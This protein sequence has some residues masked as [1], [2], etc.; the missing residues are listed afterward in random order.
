MY[1]SRTLFNGNV[2]A[3]GIK[4]RSRGSAS[5]GRS[6]GAD[7]ALGLAAIRLRSAAPGSEYSDMECQIW[8]DWQMAN[9]NAGALLANG[10][11]RKFWSG[12]AEG[13][14]VF[15][16]C[17]SCMEIQHPPRHLCG[18]CWSDNLGETESS[19]TGV[20]ESVT[21]VRRAPLPQFKPD[22]PYVIG[23]VI[24]DEGPRVI[25]TIVGDD[26]DQ[27]QIDRRVVLDILPD[28]HGNPLPRFRL[29]EDRR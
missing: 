18:S 17:N 22:L 2:C 3:G 9:D 10:D 1:W 12:L 6:I 25:A 14:L 7:F 13:R 4:I 11:S 28:A 8:E 26:A 15:Q 23:A 16:R 5:R 20:I 27:A 29:V 24:V 19:G 21:T